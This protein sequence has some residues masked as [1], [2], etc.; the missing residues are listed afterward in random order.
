MG[1]KSFCLVSVILIFGGTIEVFARSGLLEHIKQIRSFESDFI[2]YRYDQDE[3]LIVSVTGTCKLMKPDMF[4]WHYLNA[5]EKQLFTSDGITLWIYEPDLE[6]VFIKEASQIESSPVLKLL[7]QKAGSDG[8]YK[9]DQ[10]PSI[11]WYRVSLASE[12]PEFSVDVQYVDQVIKS[13]RS[14]DPSGYSTVIDFVNSKINIVFKISDFQF[15][16]PPGIDVINDYN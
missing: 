16:V 13:I 9:V 2:E 4:R 10:L 3:R 5:N 14:V 15:V 7:S 11:D 12:N 1:V 6:Q 8:L